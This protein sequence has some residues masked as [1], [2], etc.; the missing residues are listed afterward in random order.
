[1]NEDSDPFNELFAYK[2]MFK[3]SKRRESA[4]EADNR[5]LKKM[6]SNLESEVVYWKKTATK[7]SSK[8]RMA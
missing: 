1:M 3:E 4:L 8:E 5:E 6:V 2:E 7:N